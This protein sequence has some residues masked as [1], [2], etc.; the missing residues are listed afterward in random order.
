MI[1]ASLVPF[2]LPG[3]WVTGASPAMR[4][5]PG[6]AGDDKSNHALSTLP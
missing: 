5:G 4:K 1:V 6:Q 3:L 2:L